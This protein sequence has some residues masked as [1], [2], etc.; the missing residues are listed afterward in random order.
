MPQITEIVPQKKPGRVNIFLDGKFAFGLSLETLAKTD[1]AAG[2]SITQ[3]QIDQITKSEELSKLQDA[4][5][6][7]LNWRPRSEKEVGDYLTK[8]IAQKENI[9]PRQAKDSPLITKII[10]KLKRYKLIDDRQFAKWFIDSRV[11]SS[12]KSARLISLEL[13]S[14]GI[15]PQV[16]KTIIQNSPSEK[17]LATKAVAK[18]IKRWQNLPEVEFKKKL[19]QFLLMRGFDYET[20]K[21]VFAYFA[22][23][24]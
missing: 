5:V 15:D 2:Q 24:H 18:K 20:V 7:F 1:L 21:E 9:R 16:I 8:R 4:A 6:R 19:Y 13:K 3:K 11:R 22:Q 10:T 14:K 12:V 17:T 23:K